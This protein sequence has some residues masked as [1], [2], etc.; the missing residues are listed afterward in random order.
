M[1]QLIISFKKVSALICFSLLLALS[2]MSAQAAECNPLCPNGCNPDGSCKVLDVSTA[3]DPEEWEA[4]A[5][6]EARV[7]ATGG[8]A[9]AEA[10]YDAQQ[11][12][13]QQQKNNQ[14]IR[15]SNA[16]AI[17][18]ELNAQKA[19]NNQKVKDAE[20]ATQQA[21]A[22]YE[23]AQKKL[24]SA[25]TPDAMKAANDEL[26]KAKES[27][28]NA[29]DA[30]KD[31][32]KEVKKA[33][34]ALDKEAEKKIDAMD[35]SV[36]EQQKAL[37]KEQK[38]QK[39]AIEKEQDQAEDD[40]KD[41]NKKIKKLEER[42][43]KGKC[44]DED[45]ADLAAA[46]QAAADAQAALDVA[47]QKAAAF[48]AQD[49]D[50]AVDA[51]IEEQEAEIAAQEALDN[52]LATTEDA[53]KEFAEAE[54]EI[55][56]AQ[57]AAP[58]MC[59]EV[60]GNIFLLIACKAMVT[61]ADLR[62]IAYIISGFGMIALS[63]AAIFGKMNFKHLANIGI[64]LFLLSMMTPFIEYFTTGKD[65]TLMFG[66]YLPAG[67]TD[68]Q[69]SDGSV[70]N[71]DEDHNKNSTFC[72]QMIP[73]VTVTAEKKKWSLKDL[74]GSIQAGM[75]A[76]R[77]ASDMYKAAKSTVTTVKNAVSNMSAQIKS[78]GGGLD[79]IINAAGAVANATGTIVNS[80]QTLANNIATNA[81]ELSSNIRDARSTNSE[82]ESRKQLEEDTKKLESK[83]NAG[84]C[85]AEEKK[86]LEMMQQQVQDN[87]TGVNKWL[88]DDGKGGGST[89][90][91][92]INKVSN[93]TN[94]TT[95]S[96]RDA[97]NAAHEGQSIGGD[98]A[99]G[100][101]LGVG[102]GV[103]TAV[104]E[105]M[106]MAA[107]AKENGTFDFRS[108]ETKREEQKI[109]E[110][111][112]RKKTADYVKSKTEVGGVTVE[113]LGDGSTRTTKT[114]NGKTITTLIG[115][116]GKTTITSSDG[117]TIVKEKDGTK[118]V[119]DKD[120]NK[121]EYDAN[122]KVVKTT[123]A[124]PYNR[125]TSESM[126]AALKGNT[127]KEGEAAATQAQQTTNQSTGNNEEA[128]QESQASPKPLSEASKE[129]IKQACAK[130]TGDYAS[131][132][133]KCE[134]CASKQTAQEAQNCINQI[135][136][137]AKS[138]NAESVEGWCQKM[139]QTCMQATG[140]AEYDTLGCSKC[141][142]S[143]EEDQK[144]AAAKDAEGLTDE[145]KKARCNNECMVAKDSTKK[146][147]M[148]DCQAAIASAKTKTEVNTKIKEF[149]KGFYDRYNK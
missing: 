99:L 60:S 138:Q 149:K 82:R 32:E 131:F 137:E 35:K 2:S 40:L 118:T 125:P 124:N 12:R 79:G 88:E 129:Q 85:S 78:G 147:C 75:D 97:A 54:K 108:E 109:A 68:I 39:K 122:G 63:F 64:G 73:E 48:N 51:Y 25:T 27:L 141:T 3:E 139:K 148:S 105:G 80:G 42:C 16:A 126:E 136:K 43:A 30:Q 4:V 127:K 47:N 62:V 41:A 6:E 44:D 50:S 20:T 46:R 98:G 8:N 84:N 61:L 36:K 13:I 142:F 100:A 91:S 115:T 114:E 121:I 59:S 145:Q 53:S 31:V 37:E 15:D 143:L 7:N 14:S 17:Q 144:K 74:K 18:E 57:S 67:F 123:L 71:C 5:R 113:N 87:K 9:D 26:K 111:E 140:H 66:K 70:V 56:E 81:G 55:K 128:E 95:D 90:L 102:M 33:N 112:A 107:D 92:G 132:K 72:S 104:T 133:S 96:V 24:Q 120:G 117:S 130:Y 10:I 94:K 45:L 76:V 21:Q 23:A 38:K 58:T 1:K 34:K 89:I 49:E 134:A 22:A 11:S 77:N 19:Q 101:I 83:C 106:D 146:Q 119:T 116:D 110:E 65:G 135:D 29:Q 52:A 28:E 69:G 86:Y 93:I 103:G